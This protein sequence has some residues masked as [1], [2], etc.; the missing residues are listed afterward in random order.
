M[1]IFILGVG[2]FEQLTFS[3]IDKVAISDLAQISYT[4]WELHQANR[5]Q[6]LPKLVTFHVL[7]I[8]GWTCKAVQQGM[9]PIQA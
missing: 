7:L 1:R 4:E 6:L 8:R 5:L 9:Y 2:V 3:P